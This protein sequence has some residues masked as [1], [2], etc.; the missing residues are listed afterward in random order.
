MLAPRVVDALDAWR[1][2]RASSIAATSSIHPLNGREDC[3]ASE[4]EPLI[5]SESSSIASFR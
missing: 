1:E 5:G 4:T 2:L 3:V